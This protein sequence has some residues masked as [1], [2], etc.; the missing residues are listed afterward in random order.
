[1]HNMQSHC[2]AQRCRHPLHTLLSLHTPSTHTHTLHILTTH[3]LSTLHTHTT[4]SEN[5][6]THTVTAH[7]ICSLCTHSTGTF[8]VHWPSTSYTRQRIHHTQRHKSYPTDNTDCTPPQHQL[9][10]A[11]AIQNDALG[12]LV[13]NKTNILIAY[14]QTTISSSA[15][16]TI[17]N[18]KFGRFPRLL[19]THRL[20]SSH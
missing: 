6:A 16:L 4:N 8:T 20:V 15:P 13:C 19:S 11:T 2:D 5:T 3:T 7:H 18:H 1:M 9:G 17:Q 14:T 12:C 10:I